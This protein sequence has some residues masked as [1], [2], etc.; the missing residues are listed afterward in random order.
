MIIVRSIMNRYR[1]F[2][3]YTFLCCAQHHYIPLYNDNDLQLYDIFYLSHI[4][5]QF[6]FFFFFFEKYIRLLHFFMSSAALLLIISFFLKL[7]IFMVCSLKDSQN[8]FM[9][10]LNLYTSCFFSMLLNDDILYIIKPDRICLT[11]LVVDEFSEWFLHQSIFSII[12]SKS[13]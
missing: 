13:A 8:V 4:H 11:N 5:F 2:F 3:R 1:N 10:S 6:F 7:I 12:D 9:E